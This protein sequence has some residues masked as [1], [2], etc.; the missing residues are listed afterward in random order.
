MTRQVHDQFA[1]EYLEELLSPLGSVKKSQKLK[2]EVLEV[3]IWFE[4][5]S[6]SPD[7]PLGILE[8]FIKID[9]LY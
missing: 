4:A 3:N 8:W 1:K 2:S 7:I 6:L 9:F 5:S